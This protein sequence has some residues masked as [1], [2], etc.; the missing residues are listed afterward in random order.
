MK[1]A[2]SFSKAAIFALSMLLLLSCE[3]K[4]NESIQKVIEDALS[5]KL[6]A[7]EILPGQTVTVGF[8]GGSVV[9]DGRD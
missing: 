3:K 7:E 4:D 8:R 1:L 6:L 5:E 9:F 2:S